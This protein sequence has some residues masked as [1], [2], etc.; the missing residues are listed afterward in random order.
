MLS[1]VWQRCYPTL[2]KSV[3]KRW[4][5]VLSNV[6]QG[7]FQCWKQVV[8]NI[9][10]ECCQIL[11]N[12]VVECMIRVLSRIW[13]Y[14]AYIGL[15]CGFAAFMVATADWAWCLEGGRMVVENHSFLESTTAV[16]CWKDDWYAEMVV[17]GRKSWDSR[18]RV[19]EEMLIQN[20]DVYAMENKFVWVE[21]NNGFCFFVSIYFV[22]LQYRFP[23][24]DCRI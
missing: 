13:K 11:C 10:K 18:V 14:Q 17:G 24:D 22:N 19:R 16:S 9:R 21:K 8:S 6:R 23:N 4:I 3:V 12:S 5:R 20:R 2:D 15:Y 7:P 1:N